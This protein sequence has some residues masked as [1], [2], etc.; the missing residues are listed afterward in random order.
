MRGLVR[1]TVQETLNALLN[2]EDALLAK[3]ARY[4]RK[5]RQ[6]SLQKMSTTSASSSPRQGR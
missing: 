2:E 5:R 1:D 3:A 4:E 6:A